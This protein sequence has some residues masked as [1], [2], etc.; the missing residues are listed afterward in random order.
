MKPFR[1]SP[2][3]LALACAF[4]LP[5]R[6][7][8]TPLPPIETPAA[9][10]GQTVLS[11]DT[12][13][14]QTDVAVKARGN[15]VVTRDDERIEAD[16]L[17]YYQARSQARAG[18]RFVLT[19]PGARVEGS[20]LDYALDT[21]TGNADDPSFSA[22][23]NGR[24]I[25]GDGDTLDFRGPNRYRL[26][27]ARANTCEPND[28]SW[29]IKARTI[30]LDYNT[31]VG[32]A[33]NARLEFQG[34]PIL[35][36]PWIDFPLDNRRKSGF[37]V[38]TF[39]TGSESEISLPYYFNLA[40]NYDLTLT[41]RMN[42]K[43]GARL[44]AEFRYLRPDYSGLISTDQ[45][46]DD[47]VRGG[48]RF[49][50]H[51]Q[52]TQTLPWNL[53]FGY[54]LNYV[55]DD[56]YFRDFGDRESVASNVNLVR[57]A[58]FNHH[59]S[60]NGGGM[61]SQLKL[62]RYQTLQDPVTPVD[63]PY[64]RLPQLTTNAFQYLPYNLS[65]NFYGELT[66]FAHSS[67]QEGSRLVA[68]P[69][70]TWNFDRSWGFVRP[71]FG[72]HATYYDLEGFGSQAAR[73]TSRTLPIFSTDS[74]LNFERDVT[75]RG[76]SYVQT[77]Q[78]RLYY[79]YIPTERQNDLPNFDT[80]ENDFSYAQLFTENRFS[81]NDR[82]NG[83]NQLTA[84]LS[85]RLLDT[86]DGREVLRVT[87][88][89]RYYFRKDDITLAG[90]EQERRTSGSDFLFGA[91]GEL[92]RKWSFDSAYQYNEELGKTERYNLRLQYSPAPGKTA[93][94]RYRYDRD[95][96]V[97]GSGQRDTL[98]QVDLA[99]QWPLAR[100]WYAVGRYNYSLRDKKAL[101]QLA[102]FE[103]NDGCWGVRVVGQRYV[104]DLTHTKNAVFFQLELKDLGGIGN[105]P[106]DVL[107]LSIPGYSPINETRQ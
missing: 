70:V 100:K 47:Q 60:W 3:A 9:A 83:A 43:R 76:N 75:W 6:A 39:R 80:S 34:V 46:P 11:A 26:N 8:D 85:S 1:L 95:E 41:P 7:D 97:G 2:L 90:T 50:W 64:A 93:S 106:L 21:R 20:D 5:A 88:G 53:N 36:T 69:S 102:G 89:K 28:D 48:S 37:L 59:Y 105:N 19:E 62:Q 107:R 74:G 4:A 13:E 14:G 73:T 77:L 87:A 31:N 99:F 67:K 32:V 92:T 103:Y 65:A 38:P 58:W 101:E 18:K 27:R 79:V 57:E 51:A 94:V 30:D 66:R 12:V 96:E 33:R 68:Y 61:S 56:D 42:F 35:Y 82:I 16:W 71:K 49:A 98:R 72:V 17:D 63:E 40:P 86:A 54:N 81:G 104:T 29:Y 15:V 44:G 25:R 78:P 91:S 55:S 24:Q 23:Q 84:A 45:T 52:H 22:N 10:P